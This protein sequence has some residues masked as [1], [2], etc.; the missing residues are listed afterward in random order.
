LNN[1]STF[2]PEIVA[3][4]DTLGPAT[5]PDAL[6]P[7]V[8]VFGVLAAGAGVVEAAVGV[9]QLKSRDSQPLPLEVSD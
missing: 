2:A 5:S 8:T 6:E 4:A 9:F 7:D 1:A 3:P